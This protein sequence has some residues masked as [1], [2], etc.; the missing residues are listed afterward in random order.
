MEQVIASE[1]W[2]TIASPFTNTTLADIQF[3]ENDFLQI[4]NKPQ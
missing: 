4:G 2:H 3:T 1:G